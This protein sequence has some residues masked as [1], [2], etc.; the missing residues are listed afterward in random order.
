MPFTAISLFSG[1]GGDTFGMEKA[2]GKVVAFSEMNKAAIETHLANFPDSTF[3]CEPAS[4]SGDI[5]KI[6]DAV[7][8]QYKGV[9]VVFA[10]F[11]CFVAGTLVLTQRG[12]V[13]I[14]AVSLEDKLLTHTGIFQPIVNLQGKTHSGIIYTIEVEGNP[15]SIS[16][17]P[18]H[19]FF[20]CNSSSKGLQ[21]P[22]WK[23][24]KDL[25]YNDYVGI[26]LEY[27]S[28]PSNIVKGNYAWFPLKRITTKTVFSEKVYNFEVEQDNSYCVENTIVH[29]CQ[30]LSKAGKKK[31]TDPRNQMFRQ[32]ARVANVVQP[33]YVIGENVTGLLTMKSGLN[34]SDP[35]LFDVIRQ[36]FKK[37]GYELT[38]MP[39]EATDFGVP[40][41]RKRILIVGWRSEQVFEPESF[42]ATV[43]AWGAAQPMPRMRSFVTPSLVDAHP[44]AGDLIPT[45]FATNALEVAAGATVSGTAHPFIAQL[46]ET[47]QPDSFRD[48]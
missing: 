4:K 18:E 46:L 40:Q 33:K 7:F 38:H 31:A 44:L 42:W 21:E 1:C 16:T 14:E 10:G 9:D 19:P 35:L 43:A 26:P 37:I 36:E 20:V 12:Y 29:N 24:A 11:P 3:L 45:G 27:S 23:A 41:K 5:T 13:P 6:P 15:R 48:Y 22:L 2:G 39:V 32:F 8:A 34:E 47:C 17:T 28:V 30:G 25:N